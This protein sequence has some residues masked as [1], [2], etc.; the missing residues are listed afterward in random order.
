MTMPAD[1]LTV[2]GLQ[3]N[4]WDRGVLEE[5]RVGGVHAVNATCAVWEGPAQTLATIGD[6][7]V[8]ARENPDL[9]TL[10]TSTHD[11][12]AAHATSRTAVLLGFQNT[13]PFADDYRLVEVFHRLGVR[14]AQLTYNIQNLVGGSCYEPQ[15]SGL[16]RFG[17][18]IVAEMNRVGML[19]DLSHV[20][21]RT[22]RDAVE[23]SAQPVAITHANPLWFHD[24]PRNKSAEL[25]EA[26]TKR[27]GIIGCCLYP[28][29]LAGGAEAS[30]AAYCQ[31]MH[32][33]VDLV[34]PESVAIGSDCTRNWGP[35]F[36]GYLRNGRWLPTQGSDRTPPAPAW[37]DW[38][39]GP[40]HFPVLIDGLAAAGLDETT[41]AGVLGGNW[42]RLFDE[43][44]PGQV[45]S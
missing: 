26:V 28:N 38:F 24:T 11:I 35:E 45:S 18:T 42:L 25:I 21:E 22:S 32:R 13:S 1:V 10:A 40:A 12:R 5:L 39:T 9:I 14:I 33:L 19:V 31:M 17:Q 37:P 4:N 8:L 34:G 20:G 16:T 23:A 27:G 7:L 2:D 44:F 15:D 30:L 29:T 3:I 6:W 36:I 41:I 43:V